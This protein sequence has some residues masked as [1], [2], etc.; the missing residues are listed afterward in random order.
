MT[1]SLAVEPMRSPFTCH[2]TAVHYHL[3]RAISRRCRRSTMRVTIMRPIANIDLQVQRERTSVEATRR[4]VPRDR[5]NSGKPMKPV[6]IEKPIPMKRL[7]ANTVAGDY[8][9][10]GNSEQ[11]SDMTSDAT[12]GTL[13]ANKSQKQNNTKSGTHKSD[14]A[15]IRPDTPP[16]DYD[17]NDMEHNNNNH[18]K[19]NPNNS[20][21]TTAHQTNQRATVY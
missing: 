15:V 21:P 8:A 1:R 17:V 2:Q 12:D 16:A 9:R 7:F 14:F 20:T 11:Q 3:I 4:R 13:R 10:S 19:N 6:S 18:R 5:T